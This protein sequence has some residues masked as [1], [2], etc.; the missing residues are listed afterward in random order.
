[1]PN[2]THETHPKVFAAASSC[3]RGP[4]VLRPSMLAWR[5]H[6]RLPVFQKEL[7]D[8]LARLSWRVCRPVDTQRD[9]NSMKNSGDSSQMV[10]FRLSTF[11]KW[12]AQSSFVVTVLL[13]SHVAFTAIV[14]LSFSLLTATLW[15]TC[16]LHYVVNRGRRFHRSSSSWWWRVENALL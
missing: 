4:L 1:M 3:D 14:F 9:G 13:H 2:K 7:P 16:V 10:C 6:V 8:D 5:C 11:F 12:F 15:R